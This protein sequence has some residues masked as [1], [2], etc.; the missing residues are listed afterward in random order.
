MT[1][2]I[3]KGSLVFTLK[4]AGIKPL[5]QKVFWQELSFCKRQLEM[6]REVF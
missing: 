4:E 1:N 6:S 2:I 5:H 3:D